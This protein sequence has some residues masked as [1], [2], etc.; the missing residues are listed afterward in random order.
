MP[1]SS[2][3][4][5]H[6]AL[7]HGVELSRYLGG[8]MP[9]MQAV[10]NTNGFQQILKEYQPEI[11]HGPMVGDVSKHTAKIWVRTYNSQ[12]LNIEVS[13]DESFEKVAFSKTNK[14]DSNKENTFTFKITNLD[15]NTMYFYRITTP[16]ESVKTGTFQTLG[17]QVFSIAFG[18]CSA[19]IPWRE[20][21][22]STI[23][24]HRPD[25]FF[26]LGDNV[27]IDYPETPQAQL[28]CYHQRQSNV[29][30]QKFI[31]NTPTYAIWDDHD[32]GDNDDY[33]GLEKYE[34]SWKY[35]N[36]K[37]F[38]NQWANP[39]YGGGNEH[40]GVWFKKSMGDVEFFFLDGRYYR[41][42]SYIDKEKDHDLTMLG[43]EQK[44]WLKTE[45][46]KSKAKFKVLISSVPRAFNAK[47]GLEGKID[48]WLGYPEERNEIFNFLSKN[49]V[50]G[51][52]L[53]SGDRH[54]A[55]LW[56]I[57]RENDYTLYEMEVGRLTNTHRHPAMPG[58]SFSYNE[59]DA[60]GKLNFDFSKNDPSVTYEIWSIDNEK[61]FSH[62]VQ[63][64]ELK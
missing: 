16:N 3:Y 56:E 26:T 24:S 18:A 15:E 34:P 53:L 7:K 61:I 14:T 43:T 1:D 20:Y 25:A 54:R 6:E 23:H 62:T 60:F 42:P 4:Y 35:D 44:E 29:H 10:L 19:H 49:K 41:E 2:A 50:E 63:L 52:F 36:W 21:M 5:V 8:D 37:R 17:K 55:D 11:I 47:E 12:K 46:L 13:T 32:F 48:T 59:K 51:V 31:A 33:G 58:V 9:V 30:W 27:Y 64:S 22:W 38:Q 40:P 39:S 57:E 28:Y 45:I